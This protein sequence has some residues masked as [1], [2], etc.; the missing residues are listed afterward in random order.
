MA[1]VLDGA[2][3]PTSWTPIAR[4]R[5]PRDLSVHMPGSDFD[6]LPVVIPRV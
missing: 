5:E 1:I 6:E 3:L 4:V 2:R